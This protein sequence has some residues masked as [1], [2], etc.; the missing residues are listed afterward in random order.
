MKRKAERRAEEEAQAAREQ[1]ILAKAGS[2]ETR[3]ILNF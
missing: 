1:A 2:V 3:P